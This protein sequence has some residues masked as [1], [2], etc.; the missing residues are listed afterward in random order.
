MEEKVSSENTEDKKIVLFSLYGESMGIDISYV[1][2]VLAPVEIHKIP[3]TPDFIEGVINLRQHIIAVVDLRKK[4][5]IDS[6][7]EKKENYR[8]I[9]CKIKD[10][11]IG[12]IV[13]SV[14]GVISISDTQFEV[15]PDIISSNS[16]DNHILGVINVDDNIITVLNID[17]ILSQDEKTELSTIKHV[18]QK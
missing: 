18:K 15:M 11:I 9:I 17:Y 2:E 13:E 4:F 14:Q 6:E 16:K 1:R 3:N 5:A 7:I 10:F 12:L 8:I